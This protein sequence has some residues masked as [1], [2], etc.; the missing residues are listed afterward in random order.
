MAAGHDEEGWNRLGRRNGMARLRMQAWS[1]RQKG[2]K[3]RFIEDRQ[4]LENREV[5]GV[6]TEECA[7]DS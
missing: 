5:F 6:N 7:R 2:K 1:W 3:G 4:S